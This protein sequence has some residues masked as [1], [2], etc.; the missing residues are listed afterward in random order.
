MRMLTQSE[1]YALFSNARSS[2]EV[3]CTAR[4]IGR[5]LCTRLIYA[6]ADCLLAT[7]ATH[8]ANDLR[9]LN[10]V[11]YRT[12]HTLASPTGIPAIVDLGSAFTIAN[13]AAGKLA[14]LDPKGS[15]VKYNGQ[16]SEGLG[17]GVF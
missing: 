9:P 14:G 3:A 2:V 1:L 7:C 6:H 15:N 16:A 11:S 13:W 4:K 12:F 10:S 8:R 17:K 5:L